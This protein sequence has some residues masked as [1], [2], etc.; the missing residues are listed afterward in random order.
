MNLDLWPTYDPFDP[1][2]D[3][4]IPTT[5]ANRNNDLSS[6]DNLVASI[7]FCDVD[8]PSKNWSNM[9]PIYSTSTS[10]SRSHKPVF[11]Q[12]GIDVEVQDLISGPTLYINMLSE[13]ME[14][15]RF[16][17]NHQF[18]VTNSSRDVSTGSPMDD[19]APQ[20]SQC[21]PS[22]LYYQPM[23]T[24]SL[25]SSPDYGFGSAQ[26]VSYMPDTQISSP[27]EIEQPV[28]KKPGKRKQDLS[29]KMPPVD[30]N[31]LNK[32]YIVDENGRRRRPLLFEYIRHLLSD[33]DYSDIAGYVDKRRGIFKFYQREKAAQLW[34]I[35]KGRNGHSS[36]SSRTIVNFYRNICFVF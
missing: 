36:K 9:M 18:E 29:S 13:P 20:L 7:S 12:R 25:L 5:N 8:N 31:R 3:I 27:Y 26:M 6:L 16:P 23:T 22:G 17:W 30:P 4:Q 1:F 2:D 21:H 19:F 24:N 10:G 35:I 11:D 14:D 15:S 32:W 28:I 34:G 33:P